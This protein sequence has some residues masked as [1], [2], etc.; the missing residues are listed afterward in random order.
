[1]ADQTAA[2]QKKPGPNLTP[3]F[4]QWLNST[5]VPEFK[6]K[7]IVIRLRKGF[8]VRGTIEQELETFN[9]PVQMKI[10]TEGN[11]ELKT[12]QV[13]GTRT[14][15]NVETFGR[16]KPMGI[17][18]DPN[19][20]LLKSSPKLRLRALIARGEEDAQRGDLY[21]AIQE[22]QRAID[23]QRNSSLA[24]FRI[25]EATFYQ[26]N[27]QAAA[28]AFREALDGDL[29]PKWTEVWSHIYIGKIYDLSGLRDRAMNE[30]SKARET[31]DDTGGAQQEVAKYTALP[32]K[33][34]SAPSRSSP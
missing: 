16:P 34:E 13:T 5:G 2:S 10:A 8:A 24:H 22:Y 28:S 29:D 26:K 25:G 19:N 14:D 7:Y 15:F 32:F 6:L 11:P 23:V 9:M 20:E 3:F 18:V 31:R 21:N 30:Y 33:L 4:T 27:Y 12:V 1:V 17:T